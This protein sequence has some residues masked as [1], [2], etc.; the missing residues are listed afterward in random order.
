MQ[1]DRPPAKRATVLVS[2]MGLGRCVRDLA[3][4]EELRRLIPELEVSWLAAHPCTLILDEAGEKIHPAASSLKSA[5]FAAEAA[6]E[7][8]FRW[9]GRTAGRLL[10]TTARDNAK[11]VARALADYPPDL[12]IADEAIE[13]IW[14][15]ESEPF[16]RRWSS[17][18]LFYI[19][20][21]FDSTRSSPVGKGAIEALRK[22]L[23]ARKFFRV[24][25]DHLVEGDTAA[26]IGTSDDM[27]DALLYMDMPGSKDWFEA[28]FR[29]IGYPL[30]FDPEKLISESKANLKA[31]LGYDPKKPLVIAS[32]GGTA[33]AKELLER[34]DSAAEAMASVAGSSIQLILV[35]GP[36]LPP[37]K[38]RLTSG[39]SSLKQYVPKLYEHFAAAD[40]AIVGGGLMSAVELA[41]VRTPFVYVPLVG[42]T[43]QERD[44]AGR[45]A[46]ARA[47]IKMAFYEVVPKRLA[48]EFA[49]ALDRRSSDPKSD[50]PLDGARSAA[51]LIVSTLL[52]SKLHR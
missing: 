4:I 43:E 23:R 52:V 40:F 47:G 51:E 26:F 46:R 45:L 6:V 28:T 36:R 48:E 21:S 9:N 19:A 41:A 14:L 32:I 5:S 34:V 29:P 30:R 8:G 38:L 33:A 39:L 16:F 35:G 1:E 22:R 20:D 7:P 3:F 42:C 37:Q 27:P 11:V 2:S 17:W 15:F 13:L 10:K 49:R 31:R 44:V 25:R 18:P 24:M 12:L 50:L